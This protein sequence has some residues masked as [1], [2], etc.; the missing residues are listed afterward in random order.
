MSASQTV[1][2]FFL[3][4]STATAMAQI[5]EIKAQVTTRPEVEGNVTTVEV[6]AHFVTAIRMPETV[7]SVVV[8]EP[9]L[10]QVE[11][12]DRE[13]QLVFVKALTAKPAETNLLISTNHGHEVSL[14]L[15]C[16][17]EQKST[18]PATVD[19]LLKYK[20]AHGFLIEPDSPSSFVAQTRRM[21]PDIQDAPTLTAA[22]A[23]MPVSLTKPDL[24]FASVPD[25]HGEGRG[26]RLGE[27]LMQ[28]ERAPLPAL[29]GGHVAT[30]NSTGDRVRAGVSAVVDGGQ[31]VIALFSVVNPTDHNILLMPPQ[32][33][34]GG[35]IRSGRIF[36]RSHW[37][38]ADQL[39]VT[40]FRL[41]KR[42][43]GPGE[44]ADGVVLFDRPPYKQ[45]NETLFLQM[46]EA[47]AVDRPALAPIGF[48][49][50]TLRKE[51]DHGKP[52]T[53]K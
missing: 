15:I 17:G 38:S 37:A 12:S 51:S 26:D 20:P 42:R 35:K 22:T 5:P 40:D 10:F 25:V 32:V 29:Y 2:F 3:L 45:S 43:L 34:L 47:G 4:W 36:R 9:E 7:N 14:L 27:L 33:Q 21:S 6:A 30:E 53:G 18:A 16:R 50:S 13:P 31:Q 24:P 52:T 41:S 19:F 11:H 1:C 23:K 49:I 46:A 44:R 39:P 28:Q 8:G 48:G